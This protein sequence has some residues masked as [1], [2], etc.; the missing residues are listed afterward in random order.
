MNRIH[1]ITLFLVFLWVNTTALAAT[2]EVPSRVRFADV[3]LHI[4]R[5]AVPAIQKK[6]TSITQSQKHFQLLVDRA[7]LY[8]PIIEKVLDEEGV[9]HDL[10]YMVIQESLLVGDHVS[11]TKDVGYWQFQQATAMELG[12]RM[13]RNIDE[14]MHLIT[15]TRAAAKYLNKNYDYFRNWYYALLSYN[16]GRGGVSRSYEK[17]HFAKKRIRI[18]SNT[19]QYI[20][21][22]IA[23]ILAFRKTV[24]KH[25]HPEYQLHIYDQAHG[26]TLK[27]IA[28]R[29]NADYDLLVDF[30]KWLRRK[31]RI[32]TDKPYKV[33]VP[34]SYKEYSTTMKPRFNVKDTQKRKELR[35][36]P[37]KKSDKQGRGKDV[38]RKGLSRTSG[39][40]KKKSRIPTVVINYKVCESKMASFPKVK[41]RRS[42]KRVVKVNGLPAIIA[43]K[44]DTF[45]SLAAEGGIEWAQLLAFNEIRKG[46]SVIPGAVYYL[47]T[48]KSKAGLRYHIVK[49]GDTWW[50]VAQKYG[51]KARTL[52]KRNRAKRREKL[53]P[54]SVLFLRFLKPR[55]VEI[56]YQQKN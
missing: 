17:S 31:R 21:H 25:K 56:V 10:K 38:S 41:R 54:D 33:V 27:Q 15:S 2:F 28:Q 14:R 29:F 53:Q 44:G 47:K 50:K 23:H 39:T 12:L 35:V 13:D 16:H 7:N 5:G 52:K 34:L 46:V 42:E 4:S 49:K 36:R 1:K 22:Y 19:P 6:L 37:Q 20:I 48:K 43:K 11:Y 3:M 18:D 51:I 24:G 45:A 8:F 9:P 30:N 26:Q 32:P 55:Q 40:Q